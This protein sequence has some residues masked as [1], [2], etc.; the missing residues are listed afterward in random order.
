MGE[1]C[2]MKA[3]NT[4]CKNVAKFMYLGMTITNK[5]YIHAAIKTK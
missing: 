1:C 5:N 3:A 2:N 4:F